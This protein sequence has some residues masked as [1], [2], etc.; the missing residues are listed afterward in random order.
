MNNHVCRALNSTVVLVSYTLQPVPERLERAK[1]L[2]AATVKPP[3]NYKDEK[4]IAE[5]LE[6]VVGNFDEDHKDDPYVSTFDNVT[7]TLPQF[8]HAASWNKD[9]RIGKTSVA[10]VCLGFMKKYLLYADA[11]PFVLIGFGIERFVTTL[12]AECAIDG[13]LLPE[14]L[15]ACQDWMTRDVASILLPGYR[16]VPEWRLR[17]A[18]MMV[19][20][21][22]DVCGVNMLTYVPGVSP[23]ADQR[24]AFELIQRLS[25]LP[26]NATSVPIK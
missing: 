21:E 6:N 11:P 8:G 19:I 17:S 16:D 13:F 5:Y 4:K 10:G 22:E 2:F 18:M 14:R 9:G 25:V 15:R 20:G 12:F 26:P 3:S 24:V 7:L 1:A 23:N